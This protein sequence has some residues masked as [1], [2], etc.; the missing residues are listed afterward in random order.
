MQVKGRTFRATL[1]YISQKFSKEKIQSFFSDFPEFAKT[2]NFSDI[3]WYPI[4]LF[5]DFSEKI[6]KFFGFGDRSMLVDIGSFSCLQAFETSHKLFKNLSP[7]AM[8][9]NIQTLLSSY[10]SSGK[11]E[12]ELLKQNKLKIY[13]RDFVS[14]ILIS[15]RI[16]GWISQAIKLS[17]AKEVHVHDIKTKNADICFNIEW[18]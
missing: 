17:G 11:A 2:G 15:K 1:D 7:L 13:I 3:D 16:Q 5:L 10:Y 6:D 12:Y 9:S 4:D 14:S 8:A 18:L